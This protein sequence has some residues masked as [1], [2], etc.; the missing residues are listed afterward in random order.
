VSPEEDAFQ[1]AE[2]RRVM[3]VAMTRARH[4]LTI[5]ASNARPSPFVTELR[6][7][8]TYGISTGPVAEHEAHVCGECDGRLL[9]VTGQDGRIWY[10]CEHVQHCGNLLP[11]CLSCGTDLPRHAESTLEVRCVCGASYPTCPKCEDGWLL[12]RNSRFGPF[13]GCVRF[14]TCT[15]KVTSL[16]D[17]TAEVAF[18]PRE[19]GLR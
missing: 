11:A 5:L 15:G 17:G 10:R 4:T 3:Y 13:L 2:E 8:P 19:I 16:P 12:E 1:N 14:P 18:D 7:D 9:G 6:K